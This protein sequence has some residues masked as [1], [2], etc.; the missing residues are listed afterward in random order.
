[1]TEPRRF[2]LRGHDTWQV[3][4]NASRTCRE[5]A[6]E[7]AAAIRRAQEA[8]AAAE[9]REAHRI[10]QEAQEREWKRWRASL[11]GPAL[12]EQLEV[13][14][15]RSFAAPWSSPRIR[16]RSVGRGSAARGRDL[17]VL[18]QTAR[19]AHSIGEEEGMNV[20]AVIALCES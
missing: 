6:R 9:S 15:R 1:M 19:R 11:R 2:C 8:A 18:L 7:A 10:Q 4:R 14:A 17:E 20:D 5:C 12:L 3:G 13:E 16:R